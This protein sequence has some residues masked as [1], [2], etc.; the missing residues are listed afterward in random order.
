MMYTGKRTN[1]TI[2]FD[3]IDSLRPGA[4]ATTIE[5]D[6]LRS[7]N[8]GFHNIQLRT[9]EWYRSYMIANGRHIVSWNNRYHGPSIAVETL[10]R[11]GQLIAAAEQLQSPL[12][13][14]SPRVVLSY[15]DNESLMYIS[16]RLYQ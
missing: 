12:Q 8:N 11:D 9:F 6:S 1:H 2:L 3:N 5:I 14:D 7:G 10:I 13:L 15:L 4:A 16:S